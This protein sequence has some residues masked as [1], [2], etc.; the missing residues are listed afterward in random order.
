MNS[1]VDRLSLVI[2]TQILLLTTLNIGF[3]NSTR[4][5]NEF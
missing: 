1:K 2:Q 3:E 4:Y 5:D